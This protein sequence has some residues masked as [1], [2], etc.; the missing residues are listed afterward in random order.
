MMVPRLTLTSI[1]YYNYASISA[2]K[3]IKINDYQV[4]SINARMSAL[5]ICLL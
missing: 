5:A 3:Y 2:K 4:F 1:Y